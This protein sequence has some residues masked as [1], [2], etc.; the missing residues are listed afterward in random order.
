MVRGCILGTFLESN[1]TL[2]LPPE[3]EAILESGPRAFTVREVIEGRS[4]SRFQLATVALCAL[5][6]VLDGFDAQ[7]IGFLAPA[8][9]EDLS[10]PLKTFGPIFSASLIGL[11]VAAMSVGPI[12]DRVGRKWP[13]VLSTLTFA[14][15]SLLSARA[16]TF[17]GLLVLRLLTGLGLGGSMPNAVALTS[18][19]VP[20]RLQHVFVAM[21][22]TGMPLGALIGGLASSKMIPAWG[23]RSVFYLG[24]ILPL[25]LAVVLFKVLPESVQFLSVRGADPRRIVAILKRMAPDLSAESL[26]RLRAREERRP[27]LPVKHLFTEGRALGTVLLWV[28]YFMNLLI[29]YFIVSWL[30]GLL[31]Q[32]AM[33]ISAG[34]TAIS[35]F[36]LGGVI[37]SLVEGRMMNAWGA[38]G[39]LLVEFVLSTL[40]VASLAFLGALFPLMM[41]VTLVLGIVVQGAQA[42]LNALAATFYPTAVRST[43]VGWALGVGRVGSIVGPILA[44]MLLKLEWSPQQVFLAGAAPASLAA[45]AVLVSHWLRRNAT[46]FHAAPEPRRTEAA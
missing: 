1:T 8:I 10:I 21:L 32:A 42:G 12:A 23:W 44:G 19:Y 6:V 31:R 20:R 13:A 25:V 38:Y 14:L 5:V 40:L 16:N 46:V 28:P 45:A 2:Q 36:S 34:V 9:A 15:F 17:N 4:L 7:C 26:G 18:E 39:V 41:A 3:G 43:G 37:G 33:P 11:M 24:G 35:M 29:I 30:P 22:F 27:G